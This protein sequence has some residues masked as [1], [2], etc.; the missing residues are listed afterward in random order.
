MK[1]PLAIMGG[2]T[3]AIKG[4]LRRMG[5]TVRAKFMTTHIEKYATYKKPS[6]LER[7]WIEIFTI[8]GGLLAINLIFLAKAYRETNSIDPATAAQLGDFVGGYIGTIF[9][10]VSVVFLY[11]T[12]K[13]QRET[14]TIEKF[15]TKYFELIKM[16]RD[17]VAEIGIGADLG[18]KIFVIMIREFRAILQIAK[19][20]AFENGQTFNQ[21]EFFNISYYALFFGVGPNSSRML[22]EALKGYDQSFVYEFEKSLNDKTIRSKVKSERKFKFNPFEGHQSRLGHY[23]RHLY[24]TVSYVNKQTVDIDKYEYVKTIRA[25]LTTHEQ[26][27]LF[28]NCLTPIGQVWWDENLISG[29][30]FVKNIPY[31]FFDKETEIDLTS[32]F[33]ADYFEYQE[34]KTTN[35]KDKTQPT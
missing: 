3:I 16:H 12:L 2:A 33:P 4:R 31:G 7:N 23:Y 10:L 26:A 19:C 20:V 6:W 9:A 35:D 24:Q 18:K 32:F 28:I 1:K 29:Y 14:S 22:R 27:L 15:E 17:N 5:E 8:I 30:R 11:S 25:Q 34:R 21:K 13:N